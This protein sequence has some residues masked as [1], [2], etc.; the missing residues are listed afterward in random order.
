MI[1][2]IPCNIRKIFS[3]LLSLVFVAASSRTLLGYQT[4]A[5]TSSAESGNPTETAANS[6]AELQSLVAPIALYP[7]ALVAQ[8]LSAATFPD[9]VA[10]A[11]Y[12]LQQNKS[13]TGNDLM[14]AVLA[15]VSLSVIERDLLK[16]LAVPLKGKNKIGESTSS[17]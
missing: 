7:D 8:I 5:V 3:V 2:M 10:I 9:Q 13:L 12:W 6:S 1:P 4:A 14:K 11:D 17:F 15:A 16:L